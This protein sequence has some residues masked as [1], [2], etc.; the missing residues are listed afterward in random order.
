MTLKTTLNNTKDNCRLRFSD[1]RQLDASKFFCVIK[2][3]VI[4]NST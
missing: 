4:Q 2:K 1:C 3:T